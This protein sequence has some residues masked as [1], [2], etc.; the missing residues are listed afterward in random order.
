MTLQTRGEK[1]RSIDAVPAKE[2]LK[3]KAG[4]CP[5]LSAICE[6][7]DNVF[8][9]FDENG[10]SKG[11]NCLIEVTSKDG[12]EIRIYENSGGVSDTKV[13]PLV[14]LGVPYH[15]AKGSIGTWGEGFKVAAFSLG[16]ELEVATHY[17][18]ER[19]IVVHFD[20][21]WLDTPDW[22]VPV[23]AA[24]A[25]LPEGCT[26]FRIRRL[27]RPVDWAEIMRQVSVIYGHKMH[28]ISESGRPVRIEFDIDGNRA[29][30]RPL[31]LAAPELL[32]ERLAFPPDFS[33]RQFLA[34]W[35][36][37]HGIVD[38]RLTIGLTPRH[39][40]STSGV[41]MY[42]NGRLFARALRSAAVGYAEAGN[43]ILRDHPTYWRLHAYAFFEADDGTDIPWQAPLKDGVS[44]NHPITLKFREMLKAAITPYS[45]FARIAKASELV[46]FTSEWHNLPTEQKCEVLFG[47][48]ETEA[49]AEYDRL[50]RAIKDFEPPE[51]VE[52]VDLDD[53]DGRE[54]VGELDQQAKYIRQ[55]IQ[56]RN[57]GGPALEPEVLRALNPSAFATE[58]GRGRS[59]ASKTPIPNVNKRKLTIEVDVEDLEKLTSIF[60]SSSP[61]EAVKEAI[62]YTIRSV[63]RAARK[64][65][66]RHV[67]AG[68]RT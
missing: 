46:P 28:E 49:L 52:Q 41:Y 32:R 55:L 39:N 15:A 14:R 12:G 26:E 16:N 3:N 38:C 34:K 4:V 48:D 37:P 11:L 7:L 65:R 1:I 23:Y 5:P 62:T 59:N 42:G 27:N 68:P 30:I 58:P 44:E 10:S 31:P 47:D 43:A 56:R 36:T 54:R 61:H 40:G 50:P 64:L 9:N 67:G 2:I 51:G 19:P 18:G 29:R 22:T 53:I 45:R 6:I 57:D 66:R 20:E 24:N 21:G 25:P 13:E 17:P 63:S 33:P 8:D 60:A 35:R